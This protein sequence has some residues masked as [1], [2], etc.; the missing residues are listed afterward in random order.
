MKWRGWE[1]GKAEYRFLR[2]FGGVTCRNWSGKVHPMDHALAVNGG[3]T[4]DKAGT[5]FEKQ[6]GP[7]T[8]RVYDVGNRRWHFD[9][10]D[11]R[12]VQCG[13]IVTAMARAWTQAKEDAA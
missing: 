8:V 13:T 5:A 11:G 12:A 3:W 6:L 7:V 9:R 2:E 1:C 10:R 4:P